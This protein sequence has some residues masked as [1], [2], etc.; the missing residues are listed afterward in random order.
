MV[1]SLHNK[2]TSDGYAKKTDEGGVKTYE[3]PSKEA[4]KVTHAGDGSVNVKGMDRP[5]W[6]QS[7]K[8][9]G[10]VL[11]KWF[12]YPMA[13]FAHIL[14]YGVK[15]KSGRKAH[16]AAIHGWYSVKDKDGGSAYKH[17]KLPGH[18]IKYDSGAGVY[19]HT[20]A[21][22]NQLY[23]SDGYYDTFNK[24]KQHFPADK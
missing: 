9:E 12:E 3:H 8:A 11:K 23:A 18:K 5:T 16:D 1:D 7:K 21:E 2:L 19:R 22:G 14:K 20:N 17:S 24:S 6:M 10:V 4:V 13:N 15:G